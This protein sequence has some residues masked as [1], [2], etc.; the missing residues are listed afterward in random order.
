MAVDGCPGRLRTAAVGEVGGLD[1]PEAGHGGLQ[2]PVSGDLGDAGVEGQGEPVEGFGVVDDGFGL[3]DQGCEPVPVSA[4]AA[5]GGHGGE[6]GF[7][8]VLGVE[9]LRGLDAQQ[10]EGDGEAVGGVG[11]LVWSACPA[12]SA[13]GSP[14]AQ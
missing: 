8:R 12:G 11:E 4:A 13:P 9:H 1:Q 5:A 6:R 2:H 10:M 7:N 3:I 14:R